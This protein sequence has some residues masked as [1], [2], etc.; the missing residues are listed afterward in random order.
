M[1]RSTG[2]MSITATLNQEF[3]GMSVPSPHHEVTDYMILVK[4][5]CRRGELCCEA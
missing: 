2:Y 5:K 4:N 1:Y 3:I